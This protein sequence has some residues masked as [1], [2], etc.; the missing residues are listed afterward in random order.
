MLY[1][2]IVLRLGKSGENE[3]DVMWLEKKM[4]KDEFKG[5]AFTQESSL[6]I[7]RNCPNWDALDPVSTFHVEGETARGNVELFGED[8]KP[9]PP[10]A[11]AAKKT[12]SESTSGISGSN[13][14]RI[15]CLPSSD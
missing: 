1:T 4:F 6:E 3:M 14:S 7:F 13:T 5:R 11:L 8:N 15:R 12:K 2:N 9:R 10:G